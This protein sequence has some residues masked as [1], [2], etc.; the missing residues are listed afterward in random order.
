M[1]TAA[2]PQMGENIKTYTRTGLQE[3]MFWR[4]SHGNGLVK[5]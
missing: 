1:E 4:A 2:V 5:I 3:F